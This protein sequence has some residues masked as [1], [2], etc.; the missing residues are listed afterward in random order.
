ME[1]GSG[2]DSRPIAVVAY[3]WRLQRQFTD[4]MYDKQAVSVARAKG[5]WLRITRGAF[6]RPGSPDDP[7]WQVCVIHRTLRDDDEL[8]QKLKEAVERVQQRA[9][10]PNSPINQPQ[11]RP[12]ITSSP[13]GSSGRR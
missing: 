9:R 4:L 8:P 11:K 7:E 10:D 2:L 13:A 1:P 12:D 5:P 3:T 6:L